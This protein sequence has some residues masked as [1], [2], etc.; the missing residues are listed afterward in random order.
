MF[1]V[2]TSRKPITH[3]SG[4]HTYDATYTVG[5]ERTYSVTFFATDDTAARAYADRMVTDFNVSVGKTL[6]D[7]VITRRA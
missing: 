5:R 2:D 1:A 4:W 6:R 3:V 7:E